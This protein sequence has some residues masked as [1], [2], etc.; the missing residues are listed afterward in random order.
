MMVIKILPSEAPPSDFPPVSRGFLKG[1]HFDLMLARQFSWIRN[2]R[3][4]MTLSQ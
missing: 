4:I 1:L 3:F 2:N